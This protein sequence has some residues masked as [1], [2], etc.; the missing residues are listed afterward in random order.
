MADP[1]DNNVMPELSCFG[2]ATTGGRKTRKHKS[3][4]NI[5]YNIKYTHKNKKGIRKHNRKT[6]RHR[7]YKQ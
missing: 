4:Y 3:K 6:K 7:K 5:K 1:F 2:A